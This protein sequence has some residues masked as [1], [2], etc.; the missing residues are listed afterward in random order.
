S[1]HSANDPVSR[2]YRSLALQGRNQRVLHRTNGLHA[3]GFLVGLRRNLCV[4]FGENIGGDGPGSGAISELPVPRLTAK[5]AAVGGC[6]LRYALQL[7]GSN[8]PDGPIPRCAR[9]STDQAG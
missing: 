5:S 8:L 7:P 6:P 4:G 2:P 9:K 3:P 1:V